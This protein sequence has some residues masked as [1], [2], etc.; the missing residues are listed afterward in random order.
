MSLADNILENGE[1]R[2][3]YSIPSRAVKAPQNGIAFVHVMLLL[4]GIGAKERILSIVIINYLFYL[5]GVYPLYKI[6]CISGL[7]R[8]WPLVALLSV[9]LGAWHIYRINLLAINDGIFNS[10]MLWL[11]YLIVEFVHR[12]TNDKLKLFSFSDL[13]RFVGIIVIVMITIHFRLNVILIVGSAL[14]SALSIRDFRMASWFVIICLSMILSFLAVYIFVE[15]S[16]LQDG[17]WKEYFFPLFTSVSIYHIKMQL[18]KIL[19]RLVAGLSGLTNPL[20]TLFFFIFPLSMMYYGIKGIIEENF[21]KVFI[22]GICITGLW[23]TLSFPNARV[24]WYIFPFIYL[25]LLNLKKIRFIGYAF[26]FLVFFQSFQLFYI[27]FWRSPES[28]FWLYVYENSISLPKEDP[29]LVIGSGRA[30][31]FHFNTRSYDTTPENDQIKIPKELKW[32]LIENR[33]FLYVIGDSTY[34]ASVFP[35]INEMAN[36]NDYILKRNSITP[37]LDK[38][39][40]WS[41]VEIAIKKNP[42]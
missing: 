37:D 23:F 26:V 7:R 14:L 18:W 42:K 10:Y 28:L 12:K 8:G 31:Y 5:S 20:V 1:M 6:A 21:N 24:I 15:I 30:P 2:N 17:R 11:V 25:I 32:D 34:K 41:I 35:Q 19:P 29:L 38:F 39:E 22:A 16:H 27:G 4:L 3:L 40:G 13:K 36:S 33:G 9:Y